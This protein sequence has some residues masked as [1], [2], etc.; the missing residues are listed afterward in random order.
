MPLLATNPGDAITA[1]PDDFG[2][3][4]FTMLKMYLYTKNKLSR[5][6]LSKVRAHRQTHKYR[7]TD[8]TKTVSGVGCMGLI[9]IIPIITNHSLAKN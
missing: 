9:I 7:Q 2:I 8:A 1:C 6:R 3:R 5:S 4:L